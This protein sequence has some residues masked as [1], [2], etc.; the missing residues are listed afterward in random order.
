MALPLGALFMTANRESPQREKPSRLTACEETL[1]KRLAYEAMI[2]EMSARIKSVDDLGGFLDDCAALMGKTVDAGGVFIFQYDAAAKTMNKV[3]DWVAERVTPIKG[4]MQ[5]ISI[6]AYPWWME[7]T[8]KCR[9]VRYDD[10]REIP[11]ARERDLLLSL[12]IKSLLAI[13]IYVNQACYGYLGFEDYV[14]QRTWSKEDLDLLETASRMI[15][16]VLELRAREVTVKARE[17]FLESILDAIPER[18]GV[19]D[20]NQTVLLVN[21]AFRDVY[22]QDVRPGGKCYKIYRGR[23]KACDVCAVLENLDTQSVHTSICPAPR[24]AGGLQWDEV[25]TAPYYDEEGTRAGVVKRVRDVTDRVNTQRELEESWKHFRALADYTCAW[26]SLT[27]P[28]GKF[29]Y[30]SPFCETICGYSKTQFL[31]DPN[32]FAQMTHPEDRHLLENA[33]HLSLIGQGP[34][35]AELRIRARD[36]RRCWIKWNSRPVVLED[37]SFLGVRVSIQDIT[38]QKEAEEALRETLRGLEQKVEART[39]ELKEANE[40]L[41]KTNQELNEV[42]NAL[43]LLARKVGKTR[44][45]SQRNLAL[46]I[47]S[48]TMPVLSRLEH[49]KDLNAHRVDLQCLATELRQVTSVFNGGLKP[50]MLLSPT[51]MQV[52]LMIKNGLKSR[53]IAA[54]MNVSLH[55]VKSHRRNIRSKMGLKDEKMELREFLCSTLL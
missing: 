30:I 32:L 3:A 49:A 38:A 39:R 54:Q 14:T 45:E 11:S 31:E 52:A 33:L 37:N 53:Q 48:R 4:M 2:T 40:T 18:I 24:G 8:S 10:I 51:E 27:D 9:V 28:D 41:E 46:A 5:N 55:T 36:G 20:R 50:L 25:I 42:N 17:R 29:V 43:S 34:K 16:M 15:S 21:K 22:G 44:E 7:M 12:G 1:T 19:I 6:D 26:E 23:D 47:T 35:S 13:P